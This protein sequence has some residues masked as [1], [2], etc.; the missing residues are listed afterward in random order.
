VRREVGGGVEQ[1]VITALVREIDPAQRVLHPGEV[2]LGRE[3]EQAGPPSRCGSSVGSGL[4]VR[5][6]PAG[7][8]CGYPGGAMRA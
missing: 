5:R 4:Q 8:A 7:A 3:G 1:E 6:A 2:A